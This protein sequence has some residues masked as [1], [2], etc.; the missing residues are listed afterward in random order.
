MRLLYRAEIALMII[1][2]AAAALLTVT[3]VIEL[4]RGG[5][6]DSLTDFIAACIATFW[7][8]VLWSD[9]RRQRRRFT[10]PRYSSAR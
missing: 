3:G 9:I 8:S 7:C 10:D 1:L 5:G 2:G 6:R 4:V